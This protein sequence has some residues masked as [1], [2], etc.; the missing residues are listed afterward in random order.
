MF[1]IIEKLRFG[2]VQI[3]DIATKLNQQ[4]NAIYQ[5]HVLL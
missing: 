1:D 5:E 4:A 3:A 2:E